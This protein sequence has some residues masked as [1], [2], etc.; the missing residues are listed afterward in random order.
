MATIG[1]L[2]ATKVDRL[3]LNMEGSKVGQE[4]AV[5]NGRYFGKWRLI[6]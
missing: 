5:S 2:S 1:R 4:L 3:R 6:K